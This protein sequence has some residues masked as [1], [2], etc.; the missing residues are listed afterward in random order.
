V[1]PA[2][3]AFC[4]SACLV[5]GTSTRRGGHAQSDIPPRRIGRN[6]RSLNFGLTMEDQRDDGGGKAVADG[7]TPPP[8]QGAEGDLTEKQDDASPNAG[9][10]GS[11]P[12]SEA[13]QEFDAD[14]TWVS[15]S[16]SGGNTK[17]S[18]MALLVQ[19]QAEHIDAATVLHLK[20]A[21]H[22]KVKAKFNIDLEVSRQKF[23]CRGNQLDDDSMKLA[24]LGIIQ[25]SPTA[26]RTPVFVVYNRRKKPTQL[27]AKSKPTEVR[28][29]ISSLFG[30]APRSAWRTDGNFFWEVSA[31]FT[32]ETTFGA[33]IGSLVKSHAP[34][35]APDPLNLYVDCACAMPASTQNF[36][37][38]R[39]LWWIEIVLVL[40]FRWSLANVTLLV[41]GAPLESFAPAPKTAAGLGAIH[42]AQ[43]E[44]LDLKMGDHP[45]RI[46]KLMLYPRSIRVCFSSSTK[47]GG[48]DVS[49]MVPLFGEAKHDGTPECYEAALKPAAVEQRLHTIV[50]RSLG[51]PPAL[52]KDDC[53]EVR[54]VQNALAASTTATTSD[55]AADNSES[56]SILVSVRAGDAL[57]GHPSMWVG[58]AWRIV[59]NVKPVEGA[60]FRVAPPQFAPL[61]AGQLKS[62]ISEQRPDLPP[63]TQRLIAEGKELKDS[64]LVTLKCA[65]KPLETD[66]EGMQL[67]NARALLGCGFNGVCVHCSGRYTGC[68]TALVFLLRKVF[69]VLVSACKPMSMFT[70]RTFTNTCPRACPVALFHVGAIN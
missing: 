42:N 25:K 41:N 61:S 29:E 5:A 11:Q 21:T 39:A 59:Y 65:T 9:M 8:A 64:D 17:T 67:S 16:Q 56:A 4:W 3:F 36:E 50:A 69:T 26:K 33:F 28:V 12:Q 7:T 47:A 24:P 58:E 45:A 37:A 62:L 40:L 51:I 13:K 54:L 53:I 30:G 20:E 31:S 35:R 70:T 55:E 6:D 49:H 60:A 1:L 27:P 2:D 52:D 32:P 43:L 44:S 34:S 19:V 15:T 66:S 46:G 38:S 22:R 14:V 10:L 18:R 63:N 23:V 48:G 57:N 68:N